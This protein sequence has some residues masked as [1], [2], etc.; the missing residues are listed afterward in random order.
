MKILEKLMIKKKKKNLKDKEKKEMM[1]L[2]IIHL[3]AGIYLENKEY[4]I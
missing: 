2:R 1:I 3:M 4:L